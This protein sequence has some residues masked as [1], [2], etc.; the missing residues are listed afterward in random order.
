MRHGR[1]LPLLLGILGCGTQAAPRFPPEEPVPAPVVL[2]AQF[3]AE[4]TGTIRGRVTWTGSIP[5]SNSFRDAHVT[6]P[7][8]A[9]QSDAKNRLL[10]RINPQGNGVV[11]AVLFL[12]RVDPTRSRPWDLPPLRV[13]MKDRLISVAQGEPAL[14]IT[15]FVRAGDSVQMVSHSPLLEMLRARGAAY[16]T[17]PFPEPERELSR[18]FSKPGS[19]ELSSGAGNYWA[20]SWIFATEHPYYSRTDADGRFSL[21]MVPEGSYELVCWMPNWKTERFERD[22]ENL[23]VARLWF[24]PPLEKNLAVKVR[25]GATTEAE[26]VVRET[27]FSN[28]PR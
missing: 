12:R 3:D 10:P 5:E 21:E 7:A 9:V 20:R 18:P 19:V 11:E 28:A 17:L 26:F 6:T 4:Q 8:I 24:H 1:I 14:H 25:R 15:G 2:A 16:F 13:E 23:N 27:D 22:P